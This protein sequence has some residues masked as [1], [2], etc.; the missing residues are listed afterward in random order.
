MCVHH[1][2]L[3]SQPVGVVAATLTAT[4]VLGDKAGD[5]GTG[6]MGTLF[7]VLFMCCIL[8]AMPPSL[9]LSLS[10]SISLLLYLSPSLSFCLRLCFRVFAADGTHSSMPA[11]ILQYYNAIV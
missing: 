9:S 8:C 10:V 11:A 3:L 4:S 2:Y 6:T 5:E 7:L 1:R